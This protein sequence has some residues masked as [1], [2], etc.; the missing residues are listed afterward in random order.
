MR[1][2][3]L[4][5]DLEHAERGKPGIDTLKVHHTKPI[6]RNTL[7]ADPPISKSEPS[8]ATATGISIIEHNMQ[9]MRSDGDYLNLNGNTSCA[10][11]QLP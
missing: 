2:C 5:V 8:S 11:F 6:L 1:Q 9:Q 4:R 3:V 7:A 10:Q